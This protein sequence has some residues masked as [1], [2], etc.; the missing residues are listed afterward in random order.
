MLKNQQHPDAIKQIFY[1]NPEGGNITMKEAYNLMCGRAVN[2]DLTSSK[3]EE[4]NAWVQ[5]DFKE[6]D[7]H[8]NYVTKQFHQNYGY[9]LNAVL[10]KHPIKD[11]ASETGK[12]RLVESLQRGNRQSVTLD[13]KGSDVKVFIEASPQFKSLNFFEGSGQRIRTDKLYESNSQEES[14]KVD[15]KQSQK[16]GKDGD[17][18][19]EPGGRSKKK[20]NRKRQSIS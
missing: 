4:Y 9:D 20:N 16:Q 17:E 12:T 5:L 14:Q 7:K 1:I 2:K 13:I 15:K 3:G 6:T 19:G 8:G 18:D 11:L 10:A